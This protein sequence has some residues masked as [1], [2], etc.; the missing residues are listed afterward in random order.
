MREMMRIKNKV[1][2]ETEFSSYIKSL[3]KCCNY[4]RIKIPIGILIL[5]IIN[6]YALN[7]NIPTLKSSNHNPNILHPFSINIF[8]SSI[9]SLLCGKHVV[10]YKSNIK[11][12]QF[13]LTCKF[14][15]SYIIRSEG[16]KSSKPKEVTESSKPTRF[17]LLNPPSVLLSSNQVIVGVL[18]YG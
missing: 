1:L 16:V 13:L 2:H 5:Q 10:V 11:I 12:L 15:S 7:F 8:G 18:T 9:Y 3:R 17:R 4:W 14:K 6:T